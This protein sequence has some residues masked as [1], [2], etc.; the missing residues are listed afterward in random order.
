M[1]IVG[2]SPGVGSHSVAVYECGELIDSTNLQIIGIIE[3]FAGVEVLFSIENTLAEKFS[4]KRSQY[5]NTAIQTG[6]AVNFGRRQQSQVELQR[7]LDHFNKPHTAYAKKRMEWESGLSEFEAV[8]GWAKG[9]EAGR[10]AAY[11]GY[12][13]LRDSGQ[14]LVKISG[15]DNDR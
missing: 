3:R 4:C 14:C 7:F 11:V 8:T 6:L 1:I 2:I 5:K 13:A 15:D 9:V 12:L 10:D